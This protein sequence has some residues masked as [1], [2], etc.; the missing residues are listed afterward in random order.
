MN[1]SSTRTGY[2][3]QA[4][5]AIARGLA[6]NGGLFVPNA[7]TELTRADLQALIGMD[8]RARAV[9]IMKRFLPEFSEQ[10][11]QAYA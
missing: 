3:V 5:E 10:E 7:L 6:P 1:Y 9:E 11:L 8:Y 4:A 2:P